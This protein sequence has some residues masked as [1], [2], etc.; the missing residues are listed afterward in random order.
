MLKALLEFPTE[1]FWANG[2]REHVIGKDPIEARAI[3]DT[4]YH[5]SFYTA[6]AA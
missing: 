6:A 2:I 5:S 1:H 3:Y 4:I